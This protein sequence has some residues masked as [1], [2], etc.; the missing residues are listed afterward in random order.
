MT[1]TGTILDE[2]TP[3]ARLAVLLQHFSQLD[4]DREP[5]RVM[6]PLKEV[7]LVVC[8]TITVIRRDGAGRTGL[9]RPR[10]SLV[11]YPPAG[12]RSFTL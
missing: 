2:E 4:D 6:F 10:R 9:P 11:A 5:W 7:L 12:V 8:A 1:V 3:R